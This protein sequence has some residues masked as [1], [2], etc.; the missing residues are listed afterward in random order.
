[1]SQPCSSTA[2]R[3]FLQL[4]VGVAAAAI[5]GQAAADE[6]PPL[7]ESDPTAS[8]LGYKDD[9]TKVDAAKFP[10]HKANQVCLN[11]NFYQGTAA[12]APCT[13][14]PGKSVN[15]KGWCSAYAAKP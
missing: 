2:R 10:Q 14:F 15:A 6:L 11:C 4:A 8:A 13:L 3:Q 12:R 9:A 5:A 7:S 1:M